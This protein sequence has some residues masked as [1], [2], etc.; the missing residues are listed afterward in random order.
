MCS[1]GIAEHISL[2]AR[3]LSRIQSG[4]TLIDRLNPRYLARIIRIDPWH[5]PY[6]YEG[7]ANTFVLRS[8][9]P[10]GKPNTSDDVTVTS[11]SRLRQE[12][13]AVSV[14]RA[15]R[16]PQAGS[17]LGVVDATGSSRPLGQ[18]PR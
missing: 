15:V 9:G 3:R 12:R 8:A 5:Q 18:P 16:G 10:D 14:P 6:E 11:G 4:A 17:P 1:E 13:A 2:R 7:G